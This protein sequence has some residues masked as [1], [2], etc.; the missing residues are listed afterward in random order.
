MKLFVRWALALVLAS[1]VV[2]PAYAAEGAMFHN[3]S[4]AWA[5]V[6][7][8]AGTAAWHRILHAYCVAPHTERTVSAGIW[9][10]GTISREPLHIPTYEVRV[11]VKQKDCGGHLM[12]DRTLGYDGKTP[13]YVT[14]S[15]GKYRFWHTP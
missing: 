5:W 13:Y 11:E 15:N 8:Y 1:T 9:E 2:V 10:P 6:T 14:G 7:E 3:N 4:D 12:L